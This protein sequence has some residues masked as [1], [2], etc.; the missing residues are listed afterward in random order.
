MK[1]IES[2][3]VLAKPTLWVTQTIVMQSSHRMAAT[4]LVSL[5]SSMPPPT[6]T[7]SWALFISRLRQARCQ[8]RDGPAR[9]AAG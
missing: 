5:F 1:T 3:T 9:F 8:F 6:I 4:F 2:A 7:T